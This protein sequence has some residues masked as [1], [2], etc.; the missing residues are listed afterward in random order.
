MDRT[1]VKAILKMC[2][3]AAL[4]AAVV[5]AVVGVIGYVNKWEGQYAYSNAFFLAGCLLIIAGASSRYNAGQGW[6]V[7]QQFQAESF[8]G[9]SRSEQARFIIDTSSSVSTVILGVLSGIFLIILSA[10]AAYL[11]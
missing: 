5:G 8:R 11:F 4:L 1:V 9:M 3:K 6:N 7:F 10:M 2:A